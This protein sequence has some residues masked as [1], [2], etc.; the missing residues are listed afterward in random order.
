MQ[1]IN[2]NNSPRNSNITRPSK[3]KHTARTLYEARCEHMIIVN[4]CSH[5]KFKLITAAPSLSILL[6]FNYF[7]DCCHYSSNDAS[8]AIFRCRFHHDRTHAL[9]PLLPETLMAGWHCCDED[10]DGSRSV[11]SDRK[12][13]IH[14]NFMFKLAAKCIG[15]YVALTLWIWPFLVIRKVTSYH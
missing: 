13:R 1:A 12:Q 6:S 15:T 7:L 11:F 5:K 10:G 14:I 3:G 8:H 2:G 4:V 9:G